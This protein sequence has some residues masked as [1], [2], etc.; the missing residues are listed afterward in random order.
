M[1]KR[2]WAITLFHDYFT[3][4]KSYGVLS[5]AFAANSDFELRVVNLDQFSPKSFKGVD[6]APFGGGAGMIIRADVLKEALIKGVVEAGGYSHECYKDKLRVIYPSAQGLS[7][8]HSLCQSFAESFNSKSSDRR[9]LVF[10]CGRYEG[11]DQRFIDRYVDV[12]IS[13]GRYILTGG[14]LAVMVMIDSMM[15]LIPG[16][17][18]NNE[19]LIQESFAQD[20]LEYPQYTR[21]RV[22]EGQGVPEV[23]L[24]GDHEKI[25]QWK[26]EHRRPLKD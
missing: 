8:N 2:I 25:K 3:P 17:L 20:D 12:E 10:I 6:A 7:W 4:L 18:G 16:V 26:R 13:L 21:P 24:S 11:I 15:R 1:K 5:K 19:S 22:F 14:E 9:D 23:L